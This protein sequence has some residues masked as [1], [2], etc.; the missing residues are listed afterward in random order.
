MSVGGQITG[1]QGQTS[2]LVL[3]TRLMPGAQGEQGPHHGHLFCCMVGW[4]VAAW[5]GLVPG[6]RPS[7]SESTWVPG[8]RGSGSPWVFLLCSKVRMG[9]WGAEP[10][11]GDRYFG[12]RGRVTRLGPRPAIPGIGGGPE[13]LRSY[14]Y[15]LLGLPML[16]FGGTRKD[17]DDPR[18]SNLQP[19]ASGLRTPGSQL[20]N[21]S[22]CCLW[23]HMRCGGT[24]P[25]SAAYKSSAFTPV[26][27]LWPS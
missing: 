23:D 24:D 5:N 4:V 25:G 9:T 17:L 18:I 21:L 7:G 3:F 19:T 14:I 15:L 1:G 16:R 2:Q 27:F 22:W 12:V 11:L 13:S 6:C 20:R 10:Q 26:L 8:Y